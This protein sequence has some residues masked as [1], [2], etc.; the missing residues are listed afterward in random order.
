[1]A[2]QLYEKD[3]QFYIFKTL[4]RMTDGV[5]FSAVYSEKKMKVLETNQGHYSVR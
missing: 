1:M 3:L 5:Y 4:N 2:R